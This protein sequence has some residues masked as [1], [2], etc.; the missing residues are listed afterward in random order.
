MRAQ[1]KS[2]T[3]YYPDLAA[4]YAAMLYAKAPQGKFEVDPLLTA[5]DR[6]LVKQKRIAKILGIARP[7]VTQFFSG[8]KPLPEKYRGKL[9]MLLRYAV[10]LARAECDKAERGR[11]ARY[12]G[13]PGA[14]EDIA[15]MRARAD[16][17]EKILRG[18]EKSKTGRQA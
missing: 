14:A 18:V 6:L 16:E 5:L 15:F 8:T 3:D 13:M 9:L 4:D 2:I 7:S 11:D 12:T 17:A 10:T 1:Y